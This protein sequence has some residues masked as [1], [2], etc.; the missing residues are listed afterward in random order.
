MIK[1]EVIDLN[2]DYHTLHFSDSTPDSVILNYCYHN[3]FVMLNKT[4]I[5]DNE[6]FIK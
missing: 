6:T 3:G 5:P 4:Y 1:I 2:K